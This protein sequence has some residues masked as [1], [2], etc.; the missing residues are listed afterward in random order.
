MLE[1]LPLNTSNKADRIALSR[2][3]DSEAAPVEPTQM[4]GVA[5]KLAGIWR[6]ILCLNSLGADDDFFD[7]GGHSLLAIKMANHVLKVF[8]VK[9]PIAQVFSLRTLQRMADYIEPFAEAGMLSEIDSSQPVTRPLLI[10]LSFAQERLWFL[11]QLTPGA[12]SY[13]IPMVLKING[14]LNPQR[15]RACFVYLAKRHEIL[16]TAIRLV[17]DQL[18]QH[19]AE[20]FDIQM[21]VSSVEHLCAEK[22]ELETSGLIEHEAK[23]PFTLSEVPLFRLHLIKHSDESHVLVIN[24]HHMIFDG[25]STGLFLRQL[26]DCYETE[27]GENQAALPAPQYTDFALWQRRWIDSGDSSA[28]L[29]FWKKRLQNVAPALNMP[30]DFER[31][32]GATYHGAVEKFGLPD[33]LVAPL[34]KVC[35][36]QQLTMFMLLYAAFNILLSQWTGDRDIL[37]GTPVTNRTREEFESTIGLFVN[38]IVLRTGIDETMTYEQYFKSIISNVSGSFDHADLPFN[39]LVQALNP[40]RLPGCSPLIQTMFGFQ[41]RESEISRMADLDI[42]VSYQGGDVARF[43]LVFNTFMSDGKLYGYVEYKKGLFLSSTIQPLIQQFEQVLL[44]LVAADFSVDRILKVAV[45]P[46]LPMQL[47]ELDDRVLADL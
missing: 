25:L 21:S 4:T 23:R 16:R 39:V 30:L 27:D 37:I 2:R 44:T 40:A 1:S 34:Q 28:Q 20:Q 43:D 15:L 36:E 7:L 9:L 12:A 18:V 29:D 22:R 45:M 17:D 33:A 8:Q 11:E 19:I 41:N 32:Q 46:G 10:P 38:T 14:K 35:K 47:A 26:R 3:Q 13:N 42:E 6:D 24:L 31:P 5:E